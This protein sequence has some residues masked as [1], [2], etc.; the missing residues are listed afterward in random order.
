[1]ARAPPRSFA[2]F[3]ISSV[4]RDGRRPSRASRSATTSWLLRRY[5]PDRHGAL[6]EDLGLLE[7][8]GCR[9]RKNSST[10][11]PMTVAFASASQAAA[12]AREE[13][14]R[15]EPSRRRWT[16]KL[17]TDDDLVD[18]ILRFADLRKRRKHLAAGG[19]LPQHLGIRCDDIS[20]AGNALVAAAC[21]D[22]HR[23][24]CPDIAQEERQR[25]ATQA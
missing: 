4:R 20:L 14:L 22:A 8:P 19:G 24:L 5:E 9:N 3:P 2:P 21:A 7:E 23:R 16:P 18:A 1:M 6:P 10:S 17:A 13:Q 25:F 11:I 12:Q 15:T